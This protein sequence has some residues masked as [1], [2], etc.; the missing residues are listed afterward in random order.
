M[1]ELP[2]LEVMREILEGRALRRPIAR[3]RAFHPGILKTVDPPLAELCGRTFTTVS[4]RGK[5]LI[6]TAADDL[7]LVIH[8]MIAGRLVECDSGTKVTK[9]TGLVIGFADS[10]EL[11]IVENGTRRMVRVYV[12][13]DPQHVRPLAASGVEPLSDAFSVEYLVRSFGG[14]R[15]Q[16]K[17]AIADQRTIAGIG[18]AYADE[19]MFA[20]KLSPIRYVSTLTIAEIDRL[21]AAVRE[22]LA[23]GIEQ[24]RVRAAGKLIAAHRRDFLRVYERTDEPCPACGAAIAEIRYAEMRTYYCPHCQSGD[25]TLPDRR[26]WLTR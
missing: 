3:A 23:Q 26:S 19:I 24:V 2:E 4:R 11:R 6:L 9:A 20:A 18:T 8:L 10:P 16:L 13:R 14:L 21:H 22:I 25:R 7:H 15:R 12:V 17:K 1:P 5:H